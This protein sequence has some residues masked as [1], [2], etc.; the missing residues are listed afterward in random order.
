[1]H[2]ILVSACLLGR[3]VRFDGRAKTSDDELL[4]RWR[5]EGR[6]VPFCPEVE[7]GLPV[8]RPPAEIEGGAG[9]TAVLA[10]EARVLT[11]DGTD[12]TAA[13]L[14]GAHA[15]LKAAQENDIRIAIL[16]EGSPSCGSLRIYDGRF[17]GVSVSGS[18]VTTA[19]LE[20]HG[21]TVYGE[22]RISDAARHLER[23]EG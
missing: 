1:M 2:R 21:I 16:K 7:G 14:A 10:G 12:V 11:A 9:G 17:R 23:L 8:P 13:F 4:A 3:P 18:G 22:D 19:L 6:L 20:S 15:A 5:A